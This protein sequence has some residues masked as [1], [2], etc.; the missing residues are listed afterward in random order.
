MTLITEVE[1]FIMQGPRGHIFSR[2]WPSYEQAVS[3]LDRSMNISL[4][5]QVAHNSFT[6]GSHTTKNTALQYKNVSLV[7]LIQYHSKLDCLSLSFHLHPSSIF[8]GNTGAKL[9]IGLHW[10]GRLLLL[11]SNSRLVWH[12]PSLTIVR[13]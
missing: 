8:V 11:L 12:T 13:N 3:D 4:W 7:W 2:V 9:D 5:V 10:R 1:S 6:E